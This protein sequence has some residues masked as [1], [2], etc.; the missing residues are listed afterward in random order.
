MFEEVERLFAE[1]AMF[2]VED[3]EVVVLGELYLYLVFLLED[4]NVVL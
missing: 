3:Y 1:D 2:G 4:G